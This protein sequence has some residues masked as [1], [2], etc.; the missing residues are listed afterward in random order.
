MHFRV[1]GENFICTR[2]GYFDYNKIS[3]RYTHIGYKNIS[4]ANIRV[5]LSDNE[6]QASHRKLCPTTCLRTIVCA[7]LIP[8]LL[9]N[10]KR[11]L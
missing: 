11:A 7:V 10:G 3:V 8:S 6:V 9:K 4:L 2:H 1:K 5:D